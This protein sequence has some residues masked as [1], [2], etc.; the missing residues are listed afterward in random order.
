MDEAGFRQMLL[1]RGN[2]PTGVETRINYLK[3]IEK[4]LAGLGLPFTDLDAAFEAD[5][6][7]SIIEAMRGLISDHKAGG[8]AYLLLFPR[9]EN[10]GNRLANLPTFLKHYRDFRSG[11][12]MSSREGAGT[13]LGNEGA[14]LLFD[15]ANIPFQPVRNFNRKTGVSAFRIKPKG[16]G[17]KAEEAIETTDIVEVARA[18]LIDGLPARIKAISGGDVNYL[19]YGG[20][21]LVRYELAPGIAA[22]LGLP[23]QGHT[24]GM[25]MTNAGGM[26]ASATDERTSSMNLILYGP[27]GTGKTFA[28]AG[29]AVKLCSP[30]VDPD[31]RPAVEAEYRRL[32]DARQVEF[33][34]F[35]QSYSYEDFVEGLRPPFSSKDGDGDDEKSGFRLEV[36]PGV[37]HRI[38][39]RAAASKGSTGK[40]FDL[41]GRQVFKMSIGEAANPE[42]AYLFEESLENGYALLGFGQIDWRDDRF[43]KRDA[44]IE[45]WKEEEPDAEPPTPRS[46]SVQCPDMFRNWI[47]PGDILI[48]SKGNGSFRAIGEVTGPYEYAPRE[49][50]GYFHRRAVSW[51]WS[52]RTGVPVEEI[53]A[54]RFSMRTLYMLTPS[55]L[56]MS[57]LERYITSQEPGG[58]PE[59][60]VLI[61][62]EINRA[63]I[64]KVFGELITL[65]EPDKRITPEGGGLKVRLPY[66][67][68]AFG[69][70]ANLHVI[71]TMNTADRSIALLDTALR[72]RFEFRELMP[73]PDLPEMKAAGASCGVNL[74]KLLRTLNDRIEYLFDRE[75]QIGHAYFIKCAS[76][77]DLDAVM[78]HKVIPLLAEYFYEDWSKV[79]LVLGDADTGKAGRFLER[80]ELKPPAGS[81]F[82]GGETRWRWTVRS[83]FAPDAYA[84]FQ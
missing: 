76:R 21:K 35:H 23:P 12:D 13:G 28:T 65:L 27:P 66:S 49:D 42:D 18:M 46:A 32:V 48:V 84:D 64:S 55:D 17:N 7:A 8:T 25:K 69:V 70:P 2:A 67:K 6:L 63:N 10:P 38:A 45:A 3:T 9:S 15:A 68:E 39:T 22:A 78:R 79:A 26:A 58:P 61:I 29:E 59:P 4:N 47:K 54:K 77:A 36:S 16:A 81:D 52:D 34:T 57:A 56:N 41:T 44:M 50:G 1:A 24:A 11:S 30:Q 74:G 80:T 53:Y 73:N 62:D 83:E 5:S 31:D 40:A 37:F 14:F 75:H 33:V 20:E 71:G 72:R 60:F 82:E 51:L 19:T 43:A